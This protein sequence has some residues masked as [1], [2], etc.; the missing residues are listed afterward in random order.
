MIEEKLKEYITMCN[1]FAAGTLSVEEWRNYCK[2]I[3]NE[4]EQELSN[5][6]L[7]FD[8]SQLKIQD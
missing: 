7:V 2:E 3:Y 1:S 8:I 5:K 4:L 6:E